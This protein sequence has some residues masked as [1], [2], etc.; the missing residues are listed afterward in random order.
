M[1]STEIRVENPFQK[2]ANFQIRVE[3]ESKN[4]DDGGKKKF[5]KHKKTYE[6]KTEPMPDAFFVKQEKLPKT[7][8]GGFNPLPIF[9][10][11]FL[12]EQYKCNLIFIDENVNRNCMGSM[13]NQFF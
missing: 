10:C 7:S 5:G 12:L 2:A 1:L 8:P 6:P 4:P 3:I 13:F 11:P 9:F